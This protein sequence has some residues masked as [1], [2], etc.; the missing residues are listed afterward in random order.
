[1]VRFDRLR[2]KNRPVTREG[3]QRKL[4]MTRIRGEMVPYLLDN[5]DAFFSALTLIMVPM[6]GGR[7]LTEGE[8]FKFIA[9]PEDPNRG[10]IVL[11]DHVLLFPA[12][13]MHRSAAIKEVLLEDNTL[14]GQ[15]VSVVLIPFK[16]R[17]QVPIPCI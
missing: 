9:S 1:M 11:E 7:S 15:L 8:D 13:G 6:G 5:K 10:T 17:D 12:D 16:D 2:P 3:A 14:S 4:N